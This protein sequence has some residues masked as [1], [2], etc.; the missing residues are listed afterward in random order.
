[1]NMKQINILQ[2][3]LCIVMTV[4]LFAGCAEQPASTSSDTSVSVSSAE[5]E[6]PEDPDPTEA[7]VAETADVPQLADDFAESLE[8]EAGEG[9]ARTQF[10]S[11]D[12]VV[13]ME[14]FGEGAEEAL[15][16]LA[17]RVHEFDTFLSAENERSELFY[18]NQNGRAA[19]SFDL[20]MLLSLSQEYYEATGGA[21]NAALYPVKKA[22]GF[23]DQNYRVPEKQELQKL[24]ALAD[25]MAAEILE[26][27]P[28]EWPNV[29]GGNYWDEEE[30]GLPLFT[31]I[32]YGIEGME[33]DFGG[34]AKGYIADELVQILK[35]QEGVSGALINLGGN[36]T[37]VGNK[38][39]GKDW[40]VGVKDPSGEQEYYGIATIYKYQS[41]IDELLA[42][43]VVTSGGYERYFEQDGIRY[44]HILDPAT[45]YPADAGLVSATIISEDS[46]LADALSTALFVMGLE[47][48]TEFWR[49]SPYNF[50]MIL[51]DEQGTVHVTE[52]FAEQL[53]TEYPVEILES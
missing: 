49:T 40:R 27:P 32:S 1:M 8:I 52:D 35:E 6:A 36:V 42:R 34:I 37:T 4:L 51:L 18:L 44:H 39:D 14:V 19:C 17:A 7:P 30:S 45:G 31:G 50:D 24:L 21:F 43:S 28:Y 3:I 53:I 20:Q 41:S 11:M 38:P 48:A 22:W 47:R 46:A 12:T 25:P 2:G 23:P 5:P 29:V 26:L 15:R 13:S 33:L 10:F 16:K 9:S